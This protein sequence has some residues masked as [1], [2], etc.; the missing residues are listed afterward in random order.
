MQYSL[1]QK[2]KKAFLRLTNYKS[3]YTI[4][5][6]IKQNNIIEFYIFYDILLLHNQ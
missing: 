6:S 2:K 1:F 5:H 3:N 4:I